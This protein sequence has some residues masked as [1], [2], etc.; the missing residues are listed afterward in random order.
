[1]LKKVFNIDLKKS[2]FVG[3]RWRDINAGYRAGCTNFI[4]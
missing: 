1:M 3:D 2:F 4:Y